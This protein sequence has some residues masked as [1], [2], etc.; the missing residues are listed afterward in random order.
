MSQ[1]P[2]LNIRTKPTPRTGRLGTSNSQRNLTTMRSQRTQRTQ[3]TQRSHRSY[4]SQAATHRSQRSQAATHRSNNSL[5]SA[6]TPASVRSG[7]SDASSYYDEEIDELELLRE[8]REMLTQ[9][10]WGVMGDIQMANAKKAGYKIESLPKPLD[11]QVSRE[12]A[13]AYMRNR[14][15]TT[16]QQSWCLE[17]IAV[18]PQLVDNNRKFRRRV[19]DMTRYS[20]ALAKSGPTPVPNRKKFPRRR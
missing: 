12:N 7:R 17:T 9:Q 20:E 2:Q 6:R 19:T 15:G 11:V 4:R 8:K 18:Q 14:F 16:S 13:H 1:V 5:R 10:L 3:P